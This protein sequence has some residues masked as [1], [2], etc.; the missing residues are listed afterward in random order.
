[1]YV[2][3]L[4]L[5][6]V[7]IIFLLFVAEEGVVGEKMSRE[8]KSA[9]KSCLGK[10]MEKV[11]IKQLITGLLKRGVLNLREADDVINQPANAKIIK[12]VKFLFKKG[13]RGFQVRKVDGVI[14]IT[15]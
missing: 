1:M 13:T 6:K 15:C 12:M 10:L 7:T 5:I 9:I 14:E 11:E 2:Y 8:E 3:F 4:L